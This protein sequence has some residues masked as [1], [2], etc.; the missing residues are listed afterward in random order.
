VIRVNDAT[1]EHPIRVRL[2]EVSADSGH[3]GNPNS[4]FQVGAELTVTAAWDEV[5][6]WTAVEIKLP[7][8]KWDF[9]CA[10]RVEVL[11]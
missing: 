5:P 11:P 8:D 1:P 9:C 4:L 10:C 2:L 7:D 3:A 6:G